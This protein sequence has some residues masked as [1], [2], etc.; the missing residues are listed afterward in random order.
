MLQSS[1]ESVTFYLTMIV[2]FVMAMKEKLKNI[3]ENSYNN[4]ELRVGESTVL[5]FC[6][7]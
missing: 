7:V 6:V 5:L 1:E 2:D 3:N 4:F